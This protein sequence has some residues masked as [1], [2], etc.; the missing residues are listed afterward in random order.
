M[1][2][3]LTIH[4]A[5]ADNAEVRT[6]IALHL[7]GLEVATRAR[8]FPPRDLGAYLD[9]AQSLWGGW[10]ARRLA[11]VVALAPVDKALGEIRLLLTHPEHLRRGVGRALLTHLLG[12][13]R[14]LALTRLAVRIGRDTAFGPMLAFYEAHGFRSG[15]PFGG[16]RASRA[17][18]FLHRDL[19]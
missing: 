10:R 16:H 15:A 14:A 6:S 8:A 4:P 17:V 1:P 13:A 5:S 19:G 11:G 18:R 3:S 9:P 2:S 12:E 7:A